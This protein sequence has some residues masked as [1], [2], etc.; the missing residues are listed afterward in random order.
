MLI[1]QHIASV[2][3]SL[4]DKIELNNRINA[5]LEAMA[6][7]LY[8]YWFVQFDFPDKKGKPYKS[9]GG[10]MVWNAELKRDI[11]EGWSA[12]IL[13]EYCQITR[14]VT[15]KKDDVTISTN[16]NSIPILRATNISNSEIDLNDMVYVPDNLVSEEQYLNMFDIL[17][18]MSSG[19]KEHVG[20]NALYYFDRLVSYGAFC[21]KITVNKNALFYINIFMHSLNFKQYISNSCLGTNI[22]NLTNDHITSCKILIPNGSQL[23]SFEKLVSANYH[24]IGSN[25][26][27]NQILS[28][29]RDWLL[30]MLMNGQVKVK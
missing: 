7:T 28:S 15:Y 25:I 21:S 10:K 23:S 22:N 6:K 12:G 13:S 30:P 19:S 5:E 8:N 18:T 24:K 11:P 17:I 27:Q 16:K 29:L 2:L 9:S 26:R 14:G 3:S 20:K 4:D 1:Q